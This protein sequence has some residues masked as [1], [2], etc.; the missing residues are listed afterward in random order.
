MAIPVSSSLTQLDSN[1]FFQEGFEL[2][3]DAIIPS[4]ELT[5]SF[6]PFQSKT[7]FYIYDYS[8][9]VLYENLNYNADGSYLPPP[10]GTST[11]T[12]TSNYNQFVIN[13][14]EDVYNQ[15]YTNGN[16]YAV[17]NFINYELGSEL[18]QAQALETAM[19]EGEEGAAMPDYEYDGYPYFIKEISGDRTEL[20]IQ[21][22]FLNSLQIQSYYNEFENKL[23]AREDADEFYVSFGNNRNF[24]GVNSQVQL[25][26]PGSSQPISILIKLYK[27][28]PPEFE[29]EQQIQIISKV[30]ETQVFGV[31]FQ[32]DLEFVDNLLSLK[33]PNYNIDIKD[34]IN[35]STNF[36]NLK[37]LI[38]TNSSQS[39]YQFNSLQDQKGIIL[40]KNW[41]DWNEF[42]KY[43]SAEQRLNNF[44]D[45]MVSIEAYEAELLSLE[46][47]ESSTTASINYSSSYNDVSNNI[48]KIISK[49]D[50][51][52]YFLYYI[53]GSESWPK[54]TS[55]Y[56]YTNYS[57]SSSAILN[58]FGSTDENSAY[59][60]S[61]KNQIYSASRYDGSNQD[62]LYYLIPPFITDGSNF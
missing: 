56:P 9:I 40:R 7:Q 30:G 5:G 23:N 46:T 21:N 28:L 34:R 61:G 60:N 13:P 31:Q 15:G 19:G 12:S 33:G 51:Y 58:W 16:Y 48:N 59:Y 22:N 54:Y 17:Y 11:S 14:T 8:K 47:I 32:P 29:V 49:F 3:L 38:N 20:K 37:D 44:Y 45:K 53:T 42:V 24:I 18:S 36:K 50:S 55:T 52:E 25:P 6:T 26:P 10:I 1:V 39:Y 43:S 62:Y 4:I 41:G 57:Y 27:P 2:S 35:N